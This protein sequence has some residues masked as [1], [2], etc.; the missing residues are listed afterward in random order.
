[1]KRKILIVAGDNPYPPI[2]GGRVDIWNRI[3][4]LK[5][6]GFCIDL[7]VTVKNIDEVISNK[8]EIKQFVNDIF[9]VKR[10][11]RVIDLFDNIPLQ[12]KSRECLANVILKDFYDYVLLEGDY[13]ASVLQN[14]T[15]NYK[16]VLLRS[17]N[18]ECVYFYNLYKSTNNFIKKIYY[19]TEYLKFKN[20]EPDLLNKIQNVLFIS[21]DEKVN[22]DKY[23]NGLNS[24]FLP[25]TVN[26]IFKN[27]TLNNQT[28]IFIGSLFMDNN[29]EGILWYLKNIHPNLTVKFAEYKL[30]IA[31][32]S[33]C[34]SL[35]W[36]CDE[37]RRFDNITIYDTPKSL[38]DIYAKGS[39]FINPMLH[40]AGVKLKTIEAVVNGLPVVST[41]IGNE[42]TGL[43]NYKDILIADS[44]DDFK[45]HMVLLLS[46]N[47]EKKKNIVQNSQKFIRENY[48]VYNIMKNYLD[49]LG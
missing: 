9:I 47:G 38:D 31:G 7:I 27:K 13:V 49:R 33:N 12:V 20:Y 41:L 17:H 34:T 22:Y 26:R 48:D 44:A 25:A 42:G 28:V 10:E 21:Y 18:N 36:L 39:I 30:V 24:V 4:V 23:L 11:N 46:D 2:H 1:M 14:K 6:I 16:K 35:E 40:G 37:C 5:K 15:L 43:Q 19:F 29:K 8:M 32:N 3:K 45:K